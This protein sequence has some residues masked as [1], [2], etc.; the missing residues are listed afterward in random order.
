MLCVAAAVGKEAAGVAGAIQ[1]IVDAMAR[2]SEDAGVLE[3]GCHALR[4]VV[5]HCRASFLGR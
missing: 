1:A 4:N 3:S 2:N 5:F